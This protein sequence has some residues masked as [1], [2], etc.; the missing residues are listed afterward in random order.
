MPKRSRPKPA[1][2]SAPQALPMRTCGNDRCRIRFRPERETQ[3]YHEQKC[4][5]A[6]RQRLHREGKDPA[7]LRSRARRDAR[8]LA[9]SS[10]EDRTKDEAELAKQL[11]DPTYR[12]KILAEM[13]ALARTLRQRGKKG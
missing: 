13:K 12:R 3:W 9:A 4:G 11:P 5:N 6:H 1:G 10:I 8:R 2:S 7:V